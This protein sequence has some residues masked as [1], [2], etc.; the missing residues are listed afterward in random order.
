MEFRVLGPLEVVAD[1]QPIELGGRK[2]RTLLAALLLR[3]NE[4][5]SAERLIDALWGDQPPQTAQA[6]LQVH[7]SHLRKLLGRDRIV[8]QSPGYLLRVGS[9]ELDLQRFERLLKD[10]REV[11]PPAAGQRLR[12]ALALWRGSAL[13]DFEQEP[14][15]W[16]EISRLEQLRLDAV[17]SRIDEDLVAGHHATLLPELDAMLAAH[18]YRERAHG[19]LMLALYRAGRQADA[20]EAYRSARKTLVAELGIEPGPELR[21]LER[22]ILDQDPELELPSAAVVPLPERLVPGARARLNS[23]VGRKRELREIHALLSREDVHLLTLTGPPGAGKTRLAVELTTGLGNEFPEGA[24]LVELAPISEPE[25]VALTIADALGVQQTRGRL[26]AETLAAY[27]RGRRVLL[28]LDNFEQV[29]AA[30][31]LLGDLLHEA[32]TVKLL[33]TSRAPLDLPEERIFSVPALQLPDPSSSRNLARLRRTEAIRLFVDRARDARADFELTEANADAVAELCARLDGLPLPLELAAARI[34]LLSPGAILERLGQ[35]LELLKAAPGSGVAARHRTLRSA[36]EW[37][38]DLLTAEEQVLFT[39]LAVFVGGFTLDGAAA[40]AGNLDLDVVDGVESLL[41]NSLIRSEL[42]S[43]DEA[44][45]GMLETIREYGLERLA[46]RGDGQAVRRRHADFYLLLAEEAEPALLGSQQVRWLRQ[47]DTERG[48]LRAALTWATQSGEDE[49]GLRTAAPL[50]RYWQLRASDT[51]GREYLDRLLAGGASSPSTRAKAQ[52]RAASLAYVQGDHAAV[53]RYLEASLP[54]HRALRHDHYLAGYLGLLGSSALAEGDTE[55]ARTLVEEAL[56][57]AR[58]TGDPTNEAQALAQLGH[59]LAATGELDD[60]QRTLEE[61]VR[62]ARELGNVRSVGNWTRFL[63]GI[64]LLRHDYPRARQL[65]EESLAIHRSL[66]DPW[67]ISGSLSNLA[68]LALEAKDNDTAQRLFDESLKLDRKGGYR[69][70]IVNSLDLSA[71]LAAAQDRPGRAARLYGAASFARESLGLAYLEIGW[72]DP[73]R[74]VAHLR[75]ALGD[76]AFGKAWARG[77]AMTLDEAL[78]Y[79]TEEEADLEYASPPSAQR[80]S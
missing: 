59:V 51:E 23:F 79:A 8:T 50:W 47:L 36:I 68:F 32:P 63:G 19:Q 7:V 13:A 45:F 35:R 16:A 31:P 61:S 27:L 62:R 5:V 3:A 12:E 65:F 18:P 70:R 22:A 49:V 25:L 17:E 73:A 69:Y 2:P 21:R 76:D 57:T 52:S 67:G 77:R 1:G 20:L 66:D 80:S 33:V 38:Y 34:K 30:A 43:G 15:A 28:V 74:H 54:V 41:T 40:V 37:S 29:L 60:A 64:A 44:R 10:A 9:D 55:R 72:P 6:A 39:S 58:R 11:D 24:I 53:R 4:L 26:P 46:E 56:E 42:T 78:A 14:F 48:N 71:K 75:T